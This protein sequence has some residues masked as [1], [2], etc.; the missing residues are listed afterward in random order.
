MLKR[1]DVRTSGPLEKKQMIA[2]RIKKQ[3]ACKCIPHYSSLHPLP[4]HLKRVKQIPDD[5]EHLLLLVKPL[6]SSSIETKDIKD[7]SLVESNDDV[8]EEEVVVEVAWNESVTRTEWIEANA[9]WPCDFF[10]SAVEKQAQQHH[11][12]LLSLL[13]PLIS[14]NP[15]T[16]HNDTTVHIFYKQ[17]HHPISIMCEDEMERDCRKHCAFTLVQKVADLGITDYL[18][19]DCIVVLPKEPC[20]ACAMALLHSRVESV[21]FREPTTVGALSSTINLML[22]P[23]LNHYYKLYQLVLD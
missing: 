11:Q 10:N 16:T 5:P 20:L 4:R 19:T 22:I 2:K 7:L 8:K 15:D 14:V 21:V 12:H 9:L 17:H 18:L 23:G 3:D 13:T 6:C 1:L